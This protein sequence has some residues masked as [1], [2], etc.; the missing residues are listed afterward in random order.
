MGLSWTLHGVLSLAHRHTWHLACTVQDSPQHLLWPQQPAQAPAAE[1]TAATAP[2]EAASHVME[3]LAEQ[4]AS[5]AS[6]H[7]LYEP[8]LQMPIL[9]HPS[10]SQN[11]QVVAALQ[12]TSKQLQA[13]VAQLL[14]GQLPVVLQ[15]S[16]LTTL[17]SFLQWFCRNGALLQSLDVQSQ[18]AIWV[19]DDI[20]SAL[21]DA[22]VA[23]ASSAAAANALQ[24]QS[25]S[26]GL[27]AEPRLLQHL[28][29]AHLTRLHVRVQLGCEAAVKAVAGLTRLQELELDN[30][31]VCSSVAG[32]AL[33]PLAASLQMLTQLQI[34]RVTP[35]Q[36]QHL[37]PRLQ[38]L[39]ATVTV[40]WS[41]AADVAA[42]CRPDLTAL[43]SL[44]IRAS[45]GNSSDHPDDLL[46]PLSVLQQLSCL[47]LGV[48]R[49]VQ[50]QHLQLPH[51]QQLD[52]WCSHRGVGQRLQLG[53]LTALRKLLLQ[54]YATALRQDDQLPPNLQQL[55]YVL[56]GER[57]EDDGQTSILQPL[58]V[59]GQLQKLEMQFRG[60]PAVTADELKQ[61]SSLTSLQD[62]CLSYEGCTQ[63]D[64]AAAAAAWRILPLKGLI[65]GSDNVS[66]A[67]VQQLGELQGLTQLVLQAA[68][69]S[70]SVLD[71]T[72][73]QLAVAL[74]Q[75]RKLR[76]LTVK[77][78]D[79]MAMQ[80]GVPAIGSD[81]QDPAI[82]AWHGIGGI[83][84]FLQAVDALYD[85][86]EAHVALP[87]VLQEA[88]V[89]QLNDK[90][91]QLLPRGLAR[92]CNVSAHQ[93]EVEMYSK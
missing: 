16:E 81:G 37:P 74:Q 68:G 8:Q 59:L 5:I 24:L 12:Q 58:L 27:P 88:D 82:G 71:A 83:E 38:E 35:A 19:C 46:A 21:E 6:N 76:C 17:S 75:L 49:R 53:Q 41:S 9:R 80:A 93:V 23:A 72:P 11:V 39:H 62:L 22:V 10:I 77:G 73:G 47:Q 56:I 2:A 63:G 25:F 40:D 89:Q 1:G 7:S 32:D 34:G 92:Y 79:Y 67:M 31:S 87:V 18:G 4:D 52:V 28:P 14:Q 3:P 84:A 50:L 66:A 48:V 69:L 78:Y 36:L 42:L 61:L 91:Q 29:A 51:L 55:E 30:A 33:A 26:L 86:G 44:D 20:Y 43:R 70:C 64:A 54:D 65:W 60:A 85:L 90:L 15:T 45:R 13:A 57:S